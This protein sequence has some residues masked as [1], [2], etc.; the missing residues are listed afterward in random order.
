MADKVADGIDS[1]LREF[2]RSALIDPDPDSAARAE[3]RAAKLQQVQ[4]LY[5]GNWRAP[6][7]KPHSRKMA[8]GS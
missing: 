8:T 5:P 6:R 2:A 1:V 4:A 3:D 7:K